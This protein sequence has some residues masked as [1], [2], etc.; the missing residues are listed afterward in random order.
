MP[1]IYFWL[2]KVLYDVDTETM[3]IHILE[4]VRKRW[5]YMVS[6]QKDAG[7]LSESFVN[8]QGT[9]SHESCHNYGAVPVYYLSSYVLGVRDVE[10]KLI[11]EPRLGNLSFA[12]GKVVT[13]KGLVDVSW[14]KKENDDILSFS[15]LFPDSIS[16]ELHLPVNNSCASLKINGQLILD[17]G[18][19]RSDVKIIKEGR[20]IILQG[21]KG[22]CEGIV[23]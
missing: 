14:D 16:G 21:I 12:K 20:W 3:D 17:E 8:S 4:D 19:P 22:I 15:I 23:F 7:T 18:I 13:S 6:L 2:L 9:G 5:F 11:V 1:V 10:N